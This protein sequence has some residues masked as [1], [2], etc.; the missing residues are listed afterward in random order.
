MSGTTRV[1][2]VQP[3]TEDGASAASVPLLTIAWSWDE[4]HRVG[5][6][7]RL[8]THGVALLG[9]GREARSGEE[10]LRFVRRRPGG[11]HRP[12]P[13]EAANLSRRQLLLLPRR[14]GRFEA[15]NVGKAPMHFRGSPTDSALLRPGDSLRI[16]RGLVLHL[17]EGPEGLPAHRCWDPELQF[18]FGEADPF[19]MVG[20][21]WRFWEMREQLA[22]C[23]RRPV[24]VLITG[25]S[26]TG[27]ELAARSLHGMSARAAGP[28]VARNAATIP[29]SLIDAELFGNAKNYPNPGMKERSG[30]VGEADG[31]TLFLDEIGELPQE[32]QAHLLRV[33][34]SGGEYQRL[35]ETQTRRSRFRLV[36]ATNRDPEAIKHDLRARMV[37]RVDLQPL[38]TRPSDIPLLARHLLRRIAA[39]NPDIRAGFFD[40]DE[41]GALQPRLDGEL[42]EAL[43]AHSWTT[44]ARELERLLW[45]SLSSSRGEAL[46]L[47]DPVRELL[48]LRPEPAPEQDDEAVTAAM[49]RDSLARNGGVQSRVWKELG[50]KNR[51]QLRRL[52]QRYGIELG[53]DEGR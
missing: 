41:R 42:V 29:G 23:A 25:E 35:G 34:D 3:A 50:L 36:A 5:D 26:G 15:R 38:Q 43:L 14:G 52:I 22:F 39:D 21:S 13:L 8:P 45:T 48:D 31:G 44:H 46:R 1:D 18:P 28:L 10:Q 7:A 53:R 51:F 19:G 2:L 17:D 27:K 20:E 9:R 47:T 33:L 37:L 16:G 4:P 11:T 6:V 40:H 30:L 24:H 12:G 49:I 32:H